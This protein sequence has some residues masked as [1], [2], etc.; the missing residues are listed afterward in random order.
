MPESAGQNKRSALRRSKDGCLPCRRK[1]KKCDERWPTCLRCVRT[2]SHCT[3]PPSQPTSAFPLSSSMDGNALQNNP[4]LMPLGIETDNLAISRLVV[5][6]VVENSV[7]HLYADNLQPPLTDSDFWDVTALGN[8]ENLGSSSM[9]MGL[10]PPDSLANLS[11]HP[12]HI[13][14]LTR[15][16][17]VPRPRITKSLAMRMWEYAHDFGPRII[18]PPE[19]C[20]NCDELDSEGVAPVFRQS[21]VALN[22]RASAEP[23]FQD[24]CYFYLTFLTRLFYNYALPSDTLVKWVFRKFNASSSSKYAMLAL[25]AMYRSDYQ[26]SMLASSWRTEAKELYS[27]AAVQLP[28]DL[29]DN[30]LSPWEKLTGLLGV[31][32]FEYHTGQLNKYYAHGTQ[33]VPLIKAVVGNETID[34]FNI[35]GE[36][37]FDVSMWIWCDILDSMAT[38]KPTR[39]KY[40]SDLERAAQPGTPEND[41]CPDK[42]LEWLYGIPNAFAVILAR[43]SALR[44]EKLS[45]EEKRSKG[46]ELEKL[47]RNWQIRLLRT[48]DSRLRVARM[49]T[50][51]IW[52]HTCILYVH[53]AI[54]KS[55]PSHPIV[56]DSVKN[57]IRIA[58]TLEPGGNPDCFMYIS[59]FI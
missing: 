7:F 52:R 27:Q 11:I 2:G 10:S 37:M 55:D 42:G 47:T 9:P 19:G 39:Y 22:Q 12:T 41:A 23:E 24:I 13:G 50:Q 40:E 25:A 59:Y 8:L 36:D 49:G 4:S 54:F 57:I 56:K 5:D 44:E 18:W 46:A 38:S 6:P 21:I 53:N 1:R 45:E 14:E 3:W 34:L 20:T 30:K 16:S 28:H 32:D 51:E 26:K 33:A 48:K 15:A 58:C 43:T 17:A 31:M 35:R 29:E